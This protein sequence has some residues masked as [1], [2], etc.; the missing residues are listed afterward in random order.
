[1]SQQRFRLRLSDM[2]PQLEQ[3]V[4]KQ[5]LEELATEAVRPDHRR[6]GGRLLK[7]PPNG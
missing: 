5:K 1:M 3:V 2:R 4:M 6:F 7:P